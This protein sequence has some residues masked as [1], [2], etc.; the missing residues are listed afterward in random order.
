MDQK[1]R[2]SEAAEKAK[3]AEDQGD[4]K[5]AMEEWRRFR[6]IRDAGRDPEELLAEG[7]ALSA[8]AIALTQKKSSR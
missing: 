7:V 1:Q 4:Q 6:L 3:E 5:L 2:L 8:R